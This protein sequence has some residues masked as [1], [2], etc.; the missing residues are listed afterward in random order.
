MAKDEKTIIILF[1][2]GV[3][4]LGTHKNLKI[5]AMADHR[6]EIRCTFSADGV[7][8]HEFATELDAALDAPEH[9]LGSVEHVLDKV[10]AA[11][12]AY[13]TTHVESDRAALGGAADDGWHELN[14]EGGGD[15]SDDGDDD[16][17]ASQA[18]KAKRK[19]AAEQKRAKK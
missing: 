16:A 18:A 8:I 7:D 17:D 12:N 2:S 5:M 15:D 13:M 4:S 19:R 11:A 3:G 14:N 10:I 9:P 1:I 6:E